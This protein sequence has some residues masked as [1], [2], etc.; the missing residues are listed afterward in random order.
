M[1]EIFSIMQ[2]NYCING[3]DINTL[4]DLFNKNDNS[5]YEIG[6]IGKNKII[7]KNKEENKFE[8][9]ECVCNYFDTNG[10]TDCTDIK[11]K[12][13]CQKDCCSCK[14]CYK[15]ILQKLESGDIALK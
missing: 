15:C 7:L 11:E 2:N 1:I 3:I 8:K 14:D 9:L 12:V 10:I 4:M 6:M 5:V 13:L